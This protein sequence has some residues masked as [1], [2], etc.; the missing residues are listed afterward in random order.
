MRRAW[1]WPLLGFVLG[2]LVGVTVL[3]VNVVGAGPN[4]TNRTDRAAVIDPGADEGLHDVLHVPPT[5]VDVGSRPDLVY[6]TVCGTGT[7]DPDPCTTSGTVYLRA[8][9][10]ASFTAINLTK[11]PDG[12]L[13]TQTP[14]L[15]TAGAGFDYYAVIQ[16]GLGRSMT[17]PAGGASAPQHAWTVA[18]WTT[19]ALGAH[20]FGSPR[21]PEGTVATATW[22]NGADQLGLESGGVDQQTI[23]P[24]SFDLAPDG[25][26]VVLDQV[27]RRLATFAPGSPS[28]PS[29]VPILFNGGEGDI[30]VGPDGSRYVL[31]FG[32][33]L[34]GVP[35]IRTFD[36]NGTLLA[37]TATAEDSV[38]MLRGSPIGPVTHSYPSEMWMPTGAGVPPLTPAE[39]IAAEQSARPIA[40]GQGVVV[41]MLAN[42]GRFALVAGTTVVRAWKVT[43]TTDLG[44]A[45]LAE[46]NGGNL[47]VVV[48]VWTETQ[49]EFRVL[50]LTPTGFSTHFDV[51][52]V[53][54]GDSGALSR[55]R[56][57][58]GTLYQWRSDG[59]GP[60]VVTYQIGG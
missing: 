45:Q 29:Y 15:Y 9:G 49:A 7:P 39:Q 30:N 26:V 59:T 48:R 25:S 50:Q 36:A 44:E 11:N 22:G 10:D 52:D 17:V 16:D 55:F 38:D 23:G 41:R 27:N 54:W 5:L 3:S 20:V 21:A 12:T 8:V 4:R 28:T 6:E 31:D 14:T 56:F 35:V 53:K 13:W 37:S 24:S 40:G 60:Q 58:N 57:A 43:S 32:G 2:G 51:A 33:D 46:V 1:R 42:E 34:Q 19:V 47:V 18:A